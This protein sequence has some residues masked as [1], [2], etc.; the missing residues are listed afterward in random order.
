MLIFN[1]CEVLNVM[2]DDSPH[3]EDV[4][5]TNSRLDPSKSSFVKVQL[6]LKIVDIRLNK[7]L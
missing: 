4:I 6:P 2:G 1:R 5:E 3:D 7:T